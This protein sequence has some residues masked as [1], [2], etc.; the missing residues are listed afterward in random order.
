VRLKLIECY[1]TEKSIAS[2]CELLDINRSRVYYKKQEV[3]EKDVA[4][5]NEMRSIYEEHPFYGY[6]KMHAILQSTRY[7]CNIKRVQR[8]MQLAGLKALYPSKK[9]TMPNKNHKKY[10]YLLKDLN[11]THSDQVYQVDIT[12]IKVG[13]GFCYLVCLIDVF[14]RRIVGWALSP[15]LDTPPCIEALENSL[16][17]GVV[18][19]IINSDQGSQFTSELWCNT[20]TDKGIKISMDGKGRWVDNKYIERLWRTIKNELVYLNSFN[21]L[22]ELKLSLTSYIEFYNQRRPH[23]ALGYQTPNEI[24]YKNQLFLND[25]IVLDSE[26]RA[27]RCDDEISDSQIQTNFLS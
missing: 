13:S 3:S 24:Y 4:M 26:R 2:L 25:H 11:I 8:L 27:V 18:P 9:A 6:R 10:P 5:M 15:F 7:K 16:K 1:K 14:S 23:Q 21:T 19:E 22:V 20:L 17:G 12:Y